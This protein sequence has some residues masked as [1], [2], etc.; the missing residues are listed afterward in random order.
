MFDFNVKNTFCINLDKRTDRWEKMLNMF[1]H[2]GL[3]V[4]RWKASEP[5]DV[6]DN[7]SG[8]PTQQACAQSHIRIWKHMI[9]NDLPYVFIMEDDI[10]LD[11]KWRKKLKLFSKKF[12]T[13][14][15]LLLNTDHQY[16][17]DKWI[18]T[19]GDSWLAGAYILTQKC[20]KQ[21]IE[22]GKNCYL[23]T[24][25]M[26]L[27]FQELTNNQHCYSY[28][29]YLAIQTSLDSD[30]TGSMPEFSYTK[31]INDLKLNEYSLSNYINMED[32]LFL[33][34]NGFWNGFIDKTDPV[35]IDFFIQ[36][37]QLVFGKKV[38]LGSFQYSDILLESFFGKSLLVKAKHWRYKFFFSG[39]SQQRYPTPNELNQLYTCILR[40]NYNHDNTVNLPEYLTYIYC[41]N[42]VKPLLSLKNIENVKNIPTKN[43]VAIISNG[44]SQERNLFLDKI[45]QIIHVEY[46]GPHRNNAP[47]IKYK[48]NTREFTNEISQYKFVLTL[49]NSVDETY[50][51]EKITHGFMANNIPIYWGTP[52]VKECFNPDRFVIVDQLD[53]K[54]IDQ[55]IDEILYL[56]TNEEAYVRKINHPVFKNNEMSITIESVATEI[57]NLLHL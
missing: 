9:K 50:V 47:I 17:V 56:S 48:Y 2:A 51:T 41:S 8:S 28:F 44:E 43:I 25:H 26:L 55:A 13:Y 10:T 30:I 49:E 16:A 53:Q 39:E 40:S 57:K 22:L 34:I 5:K 31:T 11:K 7:I 52:Y 37:F 4:T 38:V 21:L 18:N 33:Y 35:H 15:L 12:Q 42:F 6:M 32:P 46:R 24:D 1:Q 20:A 36:L 3:S 23:P 29:P 45:E 27:S 14:D 19:R 54:S